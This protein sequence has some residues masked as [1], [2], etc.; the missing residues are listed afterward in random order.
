MTAPDSR[1]LNLENPPAVKTGKLQP[2]KRMRVG[3]GVTLL[4]MSIFVLGARPGWFGWDFSPVIGF[5][6][7]AVFEIG[8]ALICIGGYLALASLWNHNPVSIAADI[9]LRMVCT[10]YVIAVFSGMADV[11]GFGSH[12]LPGVP[13][14][15]P[16]QA[17][18]MEVGQFFIGLGF[19][20]VIPYHKRP[21]IKPA[22]TS[23]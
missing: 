18:G 23:S 2:L 6:Q 1:N 9:G 13:Y 22:G 12:L 11:F 8:L 3:L 10:G 15:G 7:I 21:K 20:L 19:I 16:L 14:F 4:G 5:V 17:L